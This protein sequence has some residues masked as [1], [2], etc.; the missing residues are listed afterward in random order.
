MELIESSHT[1]RY[2][3]YHSLL[4]DLENL[5]YHLCTTDISSSSKT[6]L[7]DHIHTFTWETPSECERVSSSIISKPWIWSQ[8][9]NCHKLN[10][11]YE[12]VRKAV[13][14]PKF[15]SHHVGLQDPTTVMSWLQSTKKKAVCSEEHEQ[16]IQSLLGKIQ[17]NMVLS[18]NADEDNSQALFHMH[19]MLPVHDQALTTKWVQSF[20]PDAK[21]YEIY[22]AQHIIASHP[23]YTESECKQHV[24][25][26][27]K[28]GLF[29]PLLL[30]SKMVNQS[31]TLWPAI[32]TSDIPYDRNA[33][34][35]IQHF[36]TT[37]YHYD[38]PNLK[39]LVALWS[40]CKDTTLC[41]YL[42]VQLDDV[43]IN[44]RVKSDGPHCDFDLD[45]SLSKFPQF[46]LDERA[47]HENAFRIWHTMKQAMMQALPPSLFLPCNIIQSKK[48]TWGHPHL[49]LKLDVSNPE[50]PVLFF[51]PQNLGWIENNQSK[52][53]R[54]HPALASKLQRSL[55][56]LGEKLCHFDFA[57]SI[58]HPLL[59]SRALQERAR[60]CPPLHLHEID[61][62]IDN[63]HF[64][65]SLVT[66]MTPDTM[67]LCPVYSAYWDQV[68]Q[69][70]PSSQ[71]ISLQQPLHLLLWRLDTPQRAI[72]T[73]DAKESPPY[74]RDKVLL[75]HKIPASD[76]TVA[77]VCSLSQPFNIAKDL[78]Y[79]LSKY[80]DE[81]SMDKPSFYQVKKDNQQILNTNF[82]EALHSFVFEPLPKDKLT[83]IPYDT[84]TS[85]WDGK[86]GEID[87]R[88]AEMQFY[89]ET[90][91]IHRYRD[92]LALYMD[93]AKP[94]QARLALHQI[95][96]NQ[97]FSIHMPWINND[98]THAVQI[99]SSDTIPFQ[100][101]HGKSLKCVLDDHFLS[102]QSHAINKREM[103]TYVVSENEL[104][105]VYKTHEHQVH[106]IALQTKFL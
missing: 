95:S 17:E 37:M 32:P 79:I 51:K 91:E 85:G 50:K 4:A 43:A 65:N 28:Q 70:V 22:I 31:D 61:T 27:K 97:L 44:T 92:W 93:K 63:Y 14:H 7:K 11:A 82:I 34:E 38:V 84:C 52:V 76:S 46:D 103:D 99:L 33:Q 60:D 96:L 5:H 102:K 16:H 30:A 21:E 9:Q 2:H 89:P 104:H 23:K 55:C 56:V 105:C 59:S 57:K 36:K 48:I 53:D 6:T 98:E 26:W 49:Q 69:S 68:L 20:K 94:L 15:L 42:A 19:F 80:A 74:L 64:G 13:T 87:A 78:M 8:I 29:Y 41:H 24:L 90:G 101:L 77:Q 10:T 25:Q 47:S 54:V 45:Q 75:T 86:K 18:T 39:R 83:I 3:L 106:W 62:H 88:Y 1:L 66:E 12:A 73:L 100:I 67:P 35:L 81:H 40:R 58:V 71:S 72:I